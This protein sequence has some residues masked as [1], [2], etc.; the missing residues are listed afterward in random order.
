VPRLIDVTR[1]VVTAA[2]GRLGIIL[3]WLALG[4]TA[5]LQIFHA[6]STLALREYLLILVIH[7]AIAWEGWQALG[8]RRPG[9][10]AVLVQLAAL[11]FLIGMRTA[12]TETRPGFWDPHYDVW[13]SL[14]LAAL[15]TGARPFIDRGPDELR[16]ALQPLQFLLPAF[17]LAWIVAHD[18]G[19][20]LALLAVGLHSLLFAWLGKDDRESGYRITAIVGFV[21]F[22]LITFHGKLGFR[23]VSA[24]VIPVG[25][26]VLA[27]VQMLQRY[28][29]SE[30]RN[31]IRA[32]T[33]CAMLG[34]AAWYA[35][36]D[37]S[38][39]VAFNLTLFVLCLATMG[40]GALMRVRLFLLMGFGGL[41]I[42]LASILYRMLG[43]M[44]RSMR[45]TSVGLLV[46]LVG[47]LFVGGTVYYKTHR[48][49]VDARL[50]RWR[51][52]IGEW[53]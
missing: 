23:Q 20:D 30:T 39:T 40:A 47:V 32:A 53:E 37:P 14:G 41:L 24:Y 42:S 44:D 38:Y 48:E 13:V 49:R 43:A 7:A 9:I 31:R 34:S 16:R 28:M 25:L 10:A 26:G 1:Q 50:A 29:T 36:V 6:G 33:L 11:G 15:L 3:V 21:A 8:T 22:V 12:V 18:L 27:L 45:L 19:T 46:L 17:A 52:R 2:G 51:R 5:G 35:L 4:A